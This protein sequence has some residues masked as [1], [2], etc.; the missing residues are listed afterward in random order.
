MDHDLGIFWRFVGIGDTGEVLD[1]AGNGPLVEPFHIPLYAYFQRALDVAFHKVAYLSPA[2]GSSLSV[3]RDE[4]AQHTHAIAGEQLGYEGHPLY[5]GVP[6]LFG[7]TQVF[8]QALSYDIPVQT[9]HATT[10]AAELHLHCLGQ[11]CLARSGQARKPKGES[12]SI[13]HIPLQWT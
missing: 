2:F 12:F 1:L 10:P 4:G 13:C 7:E 3:R 9:L 8:S 5:V 6:I 11:S